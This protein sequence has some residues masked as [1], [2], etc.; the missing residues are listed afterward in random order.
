MM[1]F[2]PGIAIVLSTA[3]LLGNLLMPTCEAHA[4]EVTAQQVRDSI[5]RAVAFLKRQQ[6]QNGKWSEFPNNPGGLTCLCTLALLNAGVPVEDES[7]QRAL[8][9]VREIEPSR[10]YVVALQTMVLCAAEPA[11]DAQLISRNVRWLESHQNKEGAKKGSWTYAVPALGMG[12]NSNA[13]FA[14]L[15]LYEAE[16]AGVRVDAKTWRLALAYWESAQNSDFSWGYE[17][18]GGLGGRQESPGT[19]SM[20]TAGIASMI[21]ASGR[22]GQGDATVTGDTIQCCGVQQSD[23]ELDQALSWL[24]STFTV[25]TN[26]SIPDGHGRDWLFYYLYGIERVGRLTGQR[27]LVNRRGEK[28][29]W[30]REGAEMFASIQDKATGKWEGINFIEREPLIGTSMALLFMSKGRRPVLMSKVQF[31]RSNDWNHHRADVTNLTTYVEKKW[32][33]DFPIGLSWQVVDL[34]TA[35]VE[36]LLQAPVLFISGSQTPDISDQQAKRL[37]DYLDRGGSIFAEATCSAAKK[38]D[39]TD[40]DPKSFDSGFRKLMDKVFEDKPEHRLKLLTADHPVWRAEERVE[41]DQQRPLLGIEYGCRT[42]VIYA[43][44]PWQ[45]DP[46]G[47]LSCYW[48]VAAGR[49]QKFSTKIAAEIAGAHAIGINVLAYATN[50]ELKSKEENFGLKIDEQK[51]DVSDRSVMYLAKLR[52][53]GGCDAAPGA[54]PGMLGAIEREV[55]LKVAGPTEPLDITN[56]A[57]FDHQLVFMHGR[58]S[59]R[60]TP[61]EREQLKKYLSEERGGT[62]LADAICANR[63]FAEAFRREMKEIFPDNKLEPIPADHEMF[64]EAFGGFDLSKVARREPQATSA[65]D[66]AEAQIRRG[67]PE[68]EGIKIGKEGRY[69]VIFSKYDLSCALEKHDS[70]ECEGYLRE[71]AERIAINTLLYSLLK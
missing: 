1:F 2:R 14:L 9:V 44:P 59:F 18:P 4:Q 64:R 28:H 16:R 38:A 32:K 68:L 48:E 47:N 27:F 11:K 66:R 62:L 31:G 8:R 41:P 42:S 15:A 19:G 52:H 10:T 21:I 13:Q 54:L 25:R 6:N 70:I 61:A 23:K 5:E 53:P 33:K 39:R 65:D 50:R 49:E 43:P 29:D 46:P 56:Q 34:K 69:A 40:P 26:P 17:K 51:H 30:Y 58:S 67:P 7:V 63:A 12:D 71:D 20:T 37:R 57:L 55:N 60:F 45:D 3:A 36:D 24:G 22:I 35:S